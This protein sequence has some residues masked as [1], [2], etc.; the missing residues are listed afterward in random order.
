[1]AFLWLQTRKGV[2]NLPAVGLACKTLLEHLPEEKGAGLLRW[3]APVTAE[4]SETQ[5]PS[6]VEITPQASDASTQI[7]TTQTEGD[8]H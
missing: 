8:W 3:P 4:R 7:A 2:K 1:M 5:G 6:K